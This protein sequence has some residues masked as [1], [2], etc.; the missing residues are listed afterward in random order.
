VQQRLIAIG[1]SITL[2]HWDPMGGWVGAIRQASDLKVISSKREHYAAV[3]NLGISS[4][5]SADV[6]ARYVDEVS[7][8]ILATHDEEAFVALAVGINDTQLKDGK[9]FVALEDYRK[10]LTAIVDAGL[11]RNHHLIVVGLTAVNEDLTDPVPWDSTKAFRNERIAEFDQVAH[12]VARE[13]DLQFADLFSDAELR[14][15]GTHLNW[16]GL[17][18]NPMGH[19]R[20]AAVVEKALER[21]GWGEVGP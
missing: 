19:R 15:S 4:N 1:D 13:Y 5:T 10:N 20:I 2:G 12:A 7:A 9:E 17:H 8:R 3:Y 21:S 14:S 11:R 6:R 18:L 16:D